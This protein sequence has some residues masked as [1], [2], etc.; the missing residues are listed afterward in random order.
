MGTN[1]GGFPSCLGV[2]IRGILYIVSMGMGRGDWVTASL[3][4]LRV[5]KLGDTACRQVWGHCVGGL[6]RGFSGGGMGH[7]VTASLG[8]GV[9]TLRVG[10]FGVG[11]GDTACRQVWGWAWGH[12]VSVSLGPGVGTLRDGKLGDTACRQVYGREWAWGHCVTASLGL[13][14]GTLRVGKLGVGRGV[15]A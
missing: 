13:G 11:R 8:L 15:T 14:V 2:G 1:D 4:T 6:G 7:C 12:C 9:G 3:G 10:K 5:G